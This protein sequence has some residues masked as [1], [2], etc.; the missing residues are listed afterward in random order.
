M[1]D[2][3]INNRYK[4]ESEL[5]RGGMGIVYRAQDTLLERAVAVKMLWASNLGS[6]GRARLLREASSYQDLYE[7]I[8]TPGFRSQDQWQAQVQAKIQMRAN[9]HVYAGGLSDEELR[10]AKVIPCR[11][12][13]KTLAEILAKKP[14]ATIA[15]LPEGP[16][17]VPYLE[18]TTTPETLG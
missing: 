5:G 9:V 17:T 2:L 6:Q 12:V 8:M 10:D 1:L 14:N 15:V 18:E 13:E 7:R 4:L 3:L 16:Q 11:S